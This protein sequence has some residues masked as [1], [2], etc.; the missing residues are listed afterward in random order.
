M[1]RLTWAVIGSFDFVPFGVAKDRQGG[2]FDSLR[3]EQNLTKV[4][5]M[6]TKLD[7]FSI[8]LSNYC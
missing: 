1:A 4:D 7:T 8:Y 2:P 5:T 6:K 3:S